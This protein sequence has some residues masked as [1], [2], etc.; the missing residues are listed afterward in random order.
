MNVILYVLL[1]LITFGVVALLLT[2]DLFRPSP[3]RSASWT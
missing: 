3:R 2:P 1:A